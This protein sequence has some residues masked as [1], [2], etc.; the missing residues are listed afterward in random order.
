MS[1]DEI[2]AAIPHRPPFLLLDEIVSRL[3][4]TSEVAI[5]T[6]AIRVAILGRPNVGKSSLLNKLVGRERVIVS[7]IPGT[8][9]DA[10]DTASPRRFSSPSRNGRGPR[11]PPSHSTKEPR[12]STSRRATP[13]PRGVL[14]RTH[15]T[16]RTSPTSIPRLLNRSRVR[17]RFSGFKDGYTRR[18]RSDPGTG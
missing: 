16:K 18:S 13:K 8:T 3:P 10:I 9:R 2:Y 4:G 11:T 5:G 17:L 14:P 15:R 6:E 7:E 1:I 12:C